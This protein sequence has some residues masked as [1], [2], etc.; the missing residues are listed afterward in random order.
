MRILALTHR[1]PYAPNRGD[2]IRAYHML[3]ALRA[4]AEVDL[5]ALAHDAD[6][7][8][9]ARALESFG[10][11]TTTVR[12]SRLANYVRGACA[13]TGATPLTHHLL[14]APDLQAAVARSVANHRPDIVFAYGTGIAP[15]VLQQPLDGL[16]LVIDFIDVDSAKWETLASR[17]RWP[18]RAIYAREARTLRAFEARVMHAARVTL[19]VNERERV[20]AQA[21]APGAAVRVVSNGIDLASFASPEPPSALPA[22]VFTGVMDYAPNADAAVWLAREVWPAVR[23]THPDAELHLVGASPPARVRALAAAGSGITVTGTVPDVRPWLWRGAIGAAPLHVARGIQNKVLEGLAA[24]LPVVVTP[25]V[26]GGLP[27]ELLAGCAVCAGADAWVAQLRQWLDLAPP[28]RRALAARAPLDSCGWDRRLAE[29]RSVFETAAAAAP[30][31][32]RG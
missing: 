15:A 18:R 14:H 3:R 10:I 17:S 32:R 28:E 24:G 11:G 2:R 30:D 29:L 4:W 27:A 25:D 12:V 23:R 16:P 22:V 26:A 5:V 21:I 13:L 20:L 1:V 8:S 19:V 31:Q 6:E 7:A 9:K